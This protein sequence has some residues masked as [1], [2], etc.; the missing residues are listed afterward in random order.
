MC[1]RLQTLTASTCSHYSLSAV[2]N[3]GRILFRGDLINALSGE[4]CI[5]PARHANCR[6]TTTEEQAR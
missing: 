6:F 5:K 2:C 1:W 4:P 3:E